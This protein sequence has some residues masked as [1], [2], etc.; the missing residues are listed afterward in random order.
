MIC[1]KGSEISFILFRMG[2]RRHWDATGW[3]SEHISCMQSAVPLLY[4]WLTYEVPSAV[5]VCV[6]QTVWH[7]NI[8]LDLLVKKSHLCTEF[9]G[10]HVEKVKYM[11]AIWHRT[12][13]KNILTR[14]AVGKAGCNRN[15]TG[16]APVHEE[17]S[18]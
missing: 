5:P 16:M 2:A 1:C 13:Q 14:M 3:R 15:H 6:V 18:Q 7:T 4:I 9:W 12:V 10:L 11:C 8:A 17:Q